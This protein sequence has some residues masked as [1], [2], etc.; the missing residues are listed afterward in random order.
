VWAPRAIELP[1][2]V[3]ARRRHCRAKAHQQIFRCEH[4]RAAPVFPSFRECEEQRTVRTL[5]ES[6]LCDGRPS[7]VPGQP[8][9]L[10]PIVPMH[11][12]IDPPNL[13]HGQVWNRDVATSSLAELACHVLLDLAGELP[14]DGAR[15]AV[16]QQLETGQERHTAA[17][18]A[19]LERCFGGW[20]CLRRVWIG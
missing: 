9:Q 11:H 3:K 12:W 8:L 5:S 17:Q 10:L 20:C 6:L 18:R 13:R 14:N 7:D 16:E 19:A 15:C 4:Q 1:D 2:H